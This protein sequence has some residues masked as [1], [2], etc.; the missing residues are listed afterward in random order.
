[1]KQLLPHHLRQ[2]IKRRLFAVRD[3]Q[4]CLQNLNQPGFSCTGAVEAGAYRCD[5][6]RQL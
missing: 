5:W 1:M 6:T 4:F 2:L 3:M